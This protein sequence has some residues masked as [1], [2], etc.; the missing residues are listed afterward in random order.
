MY[1][2]ISIIFAEV[3]AALESSKDFVMSLINL[4]KVVINSV[5]IE[6]VVVEEL[7]I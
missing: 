5:V 1:K 6:V 7:T 2:N 3:V 4:G